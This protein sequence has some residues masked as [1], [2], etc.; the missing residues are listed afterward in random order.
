MVA[1]IA[2]ATSRTSGRSTATAIAAGTARQVSANP[3]RITW[4]APNSR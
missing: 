2:R 1:L 3:T 4:P